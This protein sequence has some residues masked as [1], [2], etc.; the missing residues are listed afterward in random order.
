MGS[1][2]PIQQALPGFPLLCTPL[3]QEQSCAKGS[4][5]KKPPK[6]QETAPWGIGVCSCGLLFPVGKRVQVPEE[7]NLQ[8]GG[9]Q[10][11]TQPRASGPGSPH[12]LSPKIGVTISGVTV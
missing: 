5:K 6:S 3:Q 8:V 7:E 12:P 9:Q 10:Q 1:G 11:V 2:D 4:K